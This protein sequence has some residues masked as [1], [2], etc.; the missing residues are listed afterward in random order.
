MCH[1]SGY[2]WFP[3]LVFGEFNPDLIAE[4]R[5][6][7]STIISPQCNMSAEKVKLVQPRPVPRMYSG[8][9][10]QRHYHIMV[11]RVKL[12]IL[13]LRTSCRAQDDGTNV[14]VS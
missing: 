12:R 11:I 4:N 9:Q 1:Y 5:I 6:F 3:Q 2:V 8:F 10:P 14:L 7:I 13:N